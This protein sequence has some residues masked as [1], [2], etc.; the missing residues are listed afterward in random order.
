MIEKWLNQLLAKGENKNVEFK[1]DPHDMDAIGRT[2]CAFLNDKG[3]SIL[4]GV[5]GHGRPVGISNPQSVSKQIQR[6]LFDGLSPKA[7]C[8]VTVEQKGEIAIVLVDVPIGQEQPYAFRNRIYIRR[9]D[10]VRDASADQISRLVRRGPAVGSRWERL[11]VLGAEFSDLDKPL[12]LETAALAA[13]RGLIFK[14]PQDPKEILRE[15]NLLADGAILN[16]ALVL[17]GKH[18]QARYPQT[19]IRAAVYQTDKTGEFN[20]RRDFEGNLFTLLKD[21]ESFLKKHIRIAASFP[22]DRFQRMDIPEYP[23]PALDEAVL[24]ALIHRDYTDFTG[25]VS[26]EIYPDEIKIW[27]PGRLPSGLAVKDLAREHP[28]LPRNPDIAQVVYLHGLIERV[29]RG[30]QSII[31][32]CLKARLVRPSWKETPAGITLSFFG[33]KSAKARSIKPN[34]RQ[35]TLLKKLKPGQRLLPANYFSQMARKVS[36]RQAQTD[37]LQLVRMGFLD[38]RGATKSVVY[39]RTKKSWQ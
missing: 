15:L 36:R 19:R 31:T 8:S 10:R 28:S 32:E 7:P 38:R 3:G 17:F 21:I 4:M 13:R 11:P 23:F 12:I 24:N 29:G 33:R 18:P 37:L 30:T 14:D 6:H 26:V 16:S 39:L 25:S 1:S 22:S 2:A 34:V 35:L 20:D 9:R 27:N 5:D